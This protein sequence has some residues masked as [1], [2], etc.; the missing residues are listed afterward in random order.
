MSRF[1]FVRSAKVAFLVWSVIASLIG[2]TQTSLADDEML[3]VSLVCPDR[4]NAE[5]LEIV[6]RSRLGTRWTTVVFAGNAPQHITL[7]ASPVNGRRFVLND[8]DVASPKSATEVELKN[9][10]SA[11]AIRTKLEGCDGGADVKARYYATLRENEMRL[12]GSDGQTAIPGNWLV[13][14]GA[15]PP[16]EEYKIK[17]RLSLLAGNGIA[18]SA[19]RTDKYPLLTPGLVAVVVGPTSK[20]SALEK[21]DTIKALVPDAFIKE[22]R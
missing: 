9:S 22:G 14:A 6:A 20:E 4:S 7:S 8:F 18:A 13:I 10:I 2:T 3:D 5:T 1:S 19:I 12:S 17:T 16:A 21:L 15:W 11:E